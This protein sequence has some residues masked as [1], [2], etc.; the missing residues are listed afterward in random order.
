LTRA[1]TS[2]PVFNI[3]GI[4]LIFIGLCVVAF[5]AQN[6]VLDGSQNL[7][8]MMNLAFWPTRFSQD[9]G[10]ADPAA[11]LSAVTYSFMHGGFAHIAVNMIWL[12]AFGSPLAGRIGAVRMAIFWVVT[13]I[14]SAFAFYAVHPN[15][16]VPL[17]GA[18]GVISGMMGAAAR[19]G[20]RRVPDV[21][22]KNRS[23]FAGPLLSIPA[24]LTSRTVLIFVATWFLINLLAGMVTLTPSVEAANI[25]WEAH[26]GGF[27]VGFLGIGFLD[28]KSPLDTPRFPGNI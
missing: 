17:V 1:R 11:W 14:A 10:F 23:E 12:A 13:S 21:L 4:I 16:M 15:D 25:A 5:L 20:F 19:Y 8:V 27:I 7:W 9:G 22:H 18:S 3:P 28:R 24:A 26:I 2:E 6:Y